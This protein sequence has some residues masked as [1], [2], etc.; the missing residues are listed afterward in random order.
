MRT[1]VALVAAATTMT[2]TPAPASAADPPPPTFGSDWDDP[3][4]AAPPVERPAG[5]SCTT[6]IVDTEFRDFTPFTGTFTP[7]AACRGPW[8]K[9]VLTLR[10]AVAGRQYDRLGYLR[11]GGV[12][13]FK[14]STPQ[15]SPDGIEWTVDKDVTGYAPLL[16]TPQPVEMLIGNVVDDT[17]TG[18]LD[19]T[20]DLT[21]HPGRA[22]G[23][24]ADRVIGLTNQHSEGTSLVGDLTVPRN[25]ERLVAEVFATGSGGGC[26]EYWYLTTPAGADYSCPAEAGPYREVQIRVDGTLAGVAAP[27]PHVYTGGWSNPFLWYTVPAPRA[28]DIAP[29]RYDLTPFAGL[30]TDGKAHRVEVSVLGVPAGRPGWDVPTAILAWQDPHRRQVT[31]ALTTVGEGPLTNTSV[32]DGRTVTTTGGHSLTTS[33]YVDTSHGR[34]STTVT[35]AVTNGSVH[36]W[37][38]GESHDALDATWTDT[39]SVTTRAGRGRPTTVATQRRYGMDG[40]TTL[41]PDARLTTTITLT[42]AATVTG[43]PGGPVRLSDTYTGEASYLTNVPRPERQGRATTRERYV[44]LTPHH[45]YDRTVATEQGRAVRP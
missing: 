9:V 27:F 44:L 7:P 5:R 40:A 20:V 35:R 14:H 12:T 41:A 2:M 13:I 16:S 33:G 43:A 15:P 11:V 28:F 31:G 30:L 4:T 8:Q 18:V 24:G 25:S 37:T 10:G 6:R 23:G 34:V 42:D 36:T 3:V 29:I 1:V 39:D 21:F 45:R 32:A 17:Y 22:P 38:E 19:I 26:E